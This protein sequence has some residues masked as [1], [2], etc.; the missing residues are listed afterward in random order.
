M[1]E[2]GGGTELEG[3]SHLSI[4]EVLSLLQDEFPDVT[5]SKIRFLESQ[6]LVDPER[7]PSGYRKFYE[8]DIERLRWVLRQQRDSFLPLK[9]IKGRLEGQGSLLDE[10]PLPEGDAQP[11][12]DGHDEAAGPAGER[13]AR[14]RSTHQKE[15]PNGGQREPSPASVEGDA[16]GEDR[17]ASNGGRGEAS[18]PVASASLREGEDD[19]GA[20]LPVA[21]RPDP[22]RGRPETPRGGRRRQPPQP[23]AGGHQEE[24]SLEE[25]VSLSGVDVETLRDLER[26]ALIAPRL[27]GGTPYY[28]QDAALIAGLAS[29][30]AR[31]GVEARHL[32]AYKAAAEREAGLVQQVVMPLI[33]QRNPEARR[34]AQA[35]VEELST[36]G[37]QLRAVLLRNALAELH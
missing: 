18:G 10:P 29:A 19:D 1:L 8:E 14:A 21:N 27:V 15:P 2:A 20:V 16:G 4:G 30:F 11:Q 6:G 22:P 25:L 37:A 7:T 36:L 17:R 34:A 24:L 26:F 13:H 12:V 32:R 5:I 31:H 28:P 23:E 35:A 33:R 9:V 3:R